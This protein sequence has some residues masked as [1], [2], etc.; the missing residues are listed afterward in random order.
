VID[1][2][3]G[4]LL[5]N[6]CLVHRLG[7]RT[8]TG[9]PGT[10]SVSGTA[11][12]WAC[13]AEEVVHL[14][15]SDGRVLRSIWQSSP[16]V[17]EGTTLL[18]AQR[19]T[20]FVPSADRSG[21]RGPQ[22]PEIEGFEAERYRDSRHGF[23]LYVPP[24]PYVAHANHET[25]AVAIVDWLD[26][27]SFVARLAPLPQPV[28]SASEADLG[29][30]ADLL[31]HEWAARYE[32]VRT[33][34]PGPTQIGGRPAWR[35]DGTARLGCTTFNFRNYLV[36]SGGLAYFLSITVAD[37][38]V[39]S[40]S[41]LAQDVLQSLRLAAPEGPL[42]LLAS[43][44]LVRS[45][46][47]GFELSRPNARWIVPNHLEGPAAVLEMARQDHAA[48]VIIRVAAPR[49]GQSLENF[50][51]DQAQQAADNLSVTKPEP[52]PTT[53]GGRPAVEISY[54]GAK[55]LSDRPAQCTLVYVSLDGRILSLALIA[56]ADADTSAQKELGA[57]RESVRFSPPP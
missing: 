12:I 3:I 23:S 21:L 35:I 14:V 18:D 19:L 26:E 36:A 24:Y 9:S 1:E 31:E 33:E 45:P 48:V 47:Y 41:V 10:P 16:L 20:E 22:G 29:R 40:E 34:K 43:G 54:E 55:V 37:R 30:V 57:I 51:A 13:G 15:D 56:A 52:K 32:D 42:A 53:L 50:A 5:P 6:P 44:N 39:S 17:G 46:Y 28:P 4:A 25:G 38:P 2:S 49:P 7:P 8:A 27:A 11:L